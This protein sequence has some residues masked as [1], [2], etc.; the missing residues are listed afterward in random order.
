MYVYA[1]L[2]LWDNKGCKFHEFGNEWMNECMYVCMDVCACENRE[3]DYAKR[4]DELVL[5][6]HL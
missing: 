6:L 2:Y 3:L 1:Y 5:E 4:V